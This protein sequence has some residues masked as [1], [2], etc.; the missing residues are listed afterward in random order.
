MR[1]RKNVDITNLTTMR[2]KGLARYY[3]EAGSIDNVK[4]G[5]RFAKIHKI[6]YYIMGNGSK[7][8]FRSPKYRG[9]LIH[10]KIVNI[11]YGD[12]KKFLR[13]G[14]GVTLSWFVAWCKK[15]LIKTFEW[16]DGIPG[17]IGGAVYMNAGA[18]GSEI[19][20]NLLEV[21][22]LDLN[23]GRLKKYKKCQLVFDHRHSSFQKEKRANFIL[24]ASFKT[25]KGNKKKI[26]RKIKMYRQHRRA[27]HPVAPSLGSVF[28]KAFYKGEW[29]PAGFL[30]DKAG[31]KELKNGR[32]EVSQKHANFIV[33]KGGAR[34]SDV[35]KLIRLMKIKVREKF[36]V[37]LKLEIQIV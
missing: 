22:T 19:S 21:I 15:E 6:P 31:C 8:L 9:L 14:S 5:V 32:A 36:G 29:V 24:E 2:I 23:T 3:L 34:S 10:N 17:T 26:T 18:F 33:N 11:S 35:L 28:K 13:V 20:D 4:R 12:N 25:S 1:I 30:L 7:I 16:A 27:A 37:R